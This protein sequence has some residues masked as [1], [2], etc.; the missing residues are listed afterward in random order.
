MDGARVAR[1]R[2][3]GSVLIAG[4]FRDMAQ[5]AGV[6]LAGTP[7]WDSAHGIRQDLEHH[8]F[9]AMT[10]KCPSIRDIADRSVSTA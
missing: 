4:A 3:D 7:A 9:K 2:I 6:S 1:S 5:D 10:T 8:G